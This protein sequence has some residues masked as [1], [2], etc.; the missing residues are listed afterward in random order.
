ML[1]AARLLISDEDVAGNVF[2]RLAHEA[3]LSRWP[4]AREIVSANRN[5]L[6]TRARLR[7]DAERWHSDNK[8]R[9]LLLPSGKRL[10][11]GQELLLSRR[12]E[13]DSQVIDYIEAS[14]RAQ[15]ERAEQDRQAERALIEAAEA[16]KRERL[17]READRLA[18]EAE[19]RD[20]AAAAAIKLAR[21]TRYAAVVAAVLALVAGARC[22]RR[23]RRT[24]GSDAARGIGADE[25]RQGQV[26]GVGSP[27]S[28]RSGAAYPVTFA[29]VPFAACR[30]ERRHGGRNLA[31][32]RGTAGEYIFGRATVCP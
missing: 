3:L 31:G 17:E 14:S 29:F 30:G 8:N 10:A 5:F 7:A 18:G 2:V 13:V 12:A 26:G 19:R 27:R 32:A 1:I 15:N 6:E 23:L 20:L 11:E 25:R 21:R 16:A 28:T 22:V 24:A 4:R 9:E